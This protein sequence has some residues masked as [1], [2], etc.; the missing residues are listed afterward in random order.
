MQEEPN[1][2]S[3]RQP[4]GAS[5]RT[6]DW[7]QGSILKNLLSLSWPMVVSNGLNVLG[8]T[9]DMIWLGKL[10][11]DSMAAVGIAGMVVMLVNAFLM[12]I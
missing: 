9:V 12:G 10:G 8:P 3:S 6:R 4:P 2:Y 5:R 1:I 11:P 7:T